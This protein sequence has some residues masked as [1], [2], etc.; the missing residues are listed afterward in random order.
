[1][2]L[3]PILRFWGM[4]FLTYP[5]LLICNIFRVKTLCSCIQAFHFCIWHQF[6]FRD[7]SRVFPGPHLFTYYADAVRKLK[8]LG[9][10]LESTQIPHS[11][12]CRDAGADLCRGA[13]FLLEFRVRQAS[14]LDPFWCLDLIHT[15]A[16]V[17]FQH[18]VRGIREAR[19]LQNRFVQLVPF[20]FGYLW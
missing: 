18:P 2:F 3:D 8:I 5:N 12:G 19:L 20:L 16:S 6:Q 7:I 13:W 10:S 17:R 1:M 11:V 9:P 14:V 4:N 15:P